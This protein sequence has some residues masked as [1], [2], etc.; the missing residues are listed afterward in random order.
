MEAMLIIYDRRPPEERAT[1]ASYRH[2][3]RV[4][5]S[6]RYEEADVVLMIHAQNQATI[7]KDTHGERRE[8]EL[9]V[10]M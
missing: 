3:M 10:M 5:G 9:E 4:A 7:V 2:A 1:E 6:R 8:F